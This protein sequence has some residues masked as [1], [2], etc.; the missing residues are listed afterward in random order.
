[1]RGGEEKENGTRDEEQIPYTLL[2]Y[3]R[4]DTLGEEEEFTMGD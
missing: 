4:Q 2:L 3:T 1:V